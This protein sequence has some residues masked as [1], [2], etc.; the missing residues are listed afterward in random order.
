MDCGLGEFCPDNY[1]N[2]LAKANHIKLAPGDHYVYVEYLSHVPD[3]ESVGGTTPRN[4]DWNDAEK[5]YYDKNGVRHLVDDSAVYITGATLELGT[6]MT[7]MVM[8]HEAGH[9][10][11]EYIVDQDATKY[12][13]GEFARGVESVGEEG[14]VNEALLKSPYITEAIKQSELQPRFTD[15]NKFSMKYAEIPASET[16]NFFYG[17]SLTEDELLSY[18]YGISIP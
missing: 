18:I 6:E 7:A 12:P 2:S 15:Q 13:A 10:W 17:I 8:A 11:I 5:F 14:F 3:G 4:P 9:S 16:L 1:I